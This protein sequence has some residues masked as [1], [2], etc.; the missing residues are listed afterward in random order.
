M[1]ESPGRDAEESCAVDG[2]HNVSGGAVLTISTITLVQ[3]D[4]RDAYS[5]LAAGARERFLSAMWDAKMACEHARTE[6]NN[7]TA[8]MERA[9]QLIGIARQH[10][11]AWQAYKK[12]RPK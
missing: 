12:E 3:T 2:L 10:F 9:V 11:E 4:P 7:Q 1:A 6:D 5:N 8:E